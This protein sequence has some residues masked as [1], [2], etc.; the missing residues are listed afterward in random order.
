MFERMT[1]RPAGLACIRR[2]VLVLLALATLAVA[3]DMSG[4]EPH[5][6]SRDMARR[7]GEAAVVARV[8]VVEESPAE[9]VSDGRE[10]RCGFSYR[11]TVVE[12]FRGPSEEVDFFFPASVDDRPK[13]GEQYLV[14]LFQ[15]PS[16]LS[17]AA[18]KVAELR[19]G[20]SESA[21]LRCSWDAAPFYVGDF[22]MTIASV[23]MGRDGTGRATVEKTD[24]R[25]LPVREYDELPK[26]ESDWSSVSDV[27]RRIVG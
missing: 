4:T 18:L 22:P 27:I 5:R 14:V 24:L 21:R 13:P 8:L 20:E 16:E 17:E 12:S 15:R 10:Q 19:G 3:C 6:V 1:L 25:F 9:F 11:A 7:I 23:Q 26:G 2:G